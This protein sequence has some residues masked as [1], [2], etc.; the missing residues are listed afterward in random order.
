MAESRGIVEPGGSDEIAAAREARRVHRDDAVAI[1][2]RPGTEVWAAL[3][4]VRPERGEWRSVEL[5]HSVSR[6]VGVFPD[7]VDL[8]ALVST[9]IGETEKHVSAVLD[10]AEEGGWILLF[11]ESDALFGKRTQV[12]D[13]HDRYAS[14]ETAY[15]LTRLELSAMRVILTPR[16]KRRWPTARLRWTL[17]RPADD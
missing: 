7:R 8:A 3:D 10:R 16:T 6:I 4:G 12:A 5:P 17:R 13:P 14:Q 11:D 9:Y 1:V 2:V 15:L